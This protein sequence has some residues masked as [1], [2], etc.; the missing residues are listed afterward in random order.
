MKEIKVAHRGSHLPQIDHN[1]IVSFNNTDYQLVPAND[2]SVCDVVVDYFSLIDRES[3]RKA[4]N[5]TFS[6]K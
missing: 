2:A 1:L 6:K 5:Q 4:F 3:F